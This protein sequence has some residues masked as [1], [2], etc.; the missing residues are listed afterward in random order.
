MQLLTVFLFFVALTGTAYAQQT[1][2]LEEV[3]KHIG[4]SVKVCG[5]VRGGRFLEQAKNSPTLLNIGAAFPNQQL[6]VVI[7]GDVRKQF[8]QAPEELFKDKEVCIVGKVELYKEKPQ[9]VLKRKE[10][11][12]LK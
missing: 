1:I 3:S 2:S 7:W 11:L 8:E 9:I 6:T 10:Q 4:D 12:L 5:V